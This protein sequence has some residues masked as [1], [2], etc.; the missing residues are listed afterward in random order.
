MVLLYVS[1]V[2]CFVPQIEPL[3]MPGSFCCHWI[4]YDTFASAPSIELK[5][6]KKQLVIFERF[7]VCV[8]RKQYSRTVI[9]CCTVVQKMNDLKCWSKAT[10]KSSTSSLVSVFIWLVW[11]MT[12]KMIRMY[13]GN[14]FFN[15]A[16][17]S[18]YCSQT[19]FAVQFNSIIYLNISG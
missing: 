8:H 7:C 5:H 3:S 2:Y 10:R 11:K 12:A 17:L 19:F 1:M 4:L 18:F 14:K 13:N 15:C 16:I 9:Y 6:T